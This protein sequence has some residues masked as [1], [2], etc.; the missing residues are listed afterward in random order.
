MAQTDPTQPPPG[1]GGFT[2][3]KPQFPPNDP[4]ANQGAY[5]AQ[6]GYAG[7]PVSPVPQY[8]TPVPYT[9]PGSPPPQ[10]AYQGD[11]KYGYA[12]PPVGGAAELGGNSSGIAPVAPA[13][14]QTA[15]APQ[16]AEMAGDSTQRAGNG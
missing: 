9:A 1:V 10:Q 12:G 15:P 13:G 3:A 11:V 4:Y 16:A 14:H 6:Q 8:S 5:N 2:D 7:A